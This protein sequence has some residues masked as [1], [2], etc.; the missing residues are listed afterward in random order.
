MRSFHIR[1]LQNPIHQTPLLAFS[2]AG[3]ASAGIEVC[4]LLNYTRALWQNGNIRSFSA[5]QMAKITR[6]ETLLALQGDQSPKVFFLP[7]H[8][9]RLAHTAE[10][11][12]LRKWPAM[13]YRYLERQNGLYMLSCLSEDL[14]KAVMQLSF[15]H[16]IEI[17]LSQHG[18]LLWFTISGILIRLKIPQAWK[19]FNWF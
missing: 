12:R 16:K 15:P 19:S 13:S 8:K 17:C 1:F 10:G 7:S 4:K 5:V 18:N 14:L 11:C 3:Q 9:Q 2:F 6:H